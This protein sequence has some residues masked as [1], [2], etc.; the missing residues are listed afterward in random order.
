MQEIVSFGKKEKEAL[1]KIEK[2]NPEFQFLN[3]SQKYKRI[4]WIGV[5]YMLKK[6]N[7]LI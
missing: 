2:Q 1:E 3:N 7:N 4:Y 5:K 6:G